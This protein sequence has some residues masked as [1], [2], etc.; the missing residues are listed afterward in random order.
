MEKYLNDLLN[1]I[2]IDNNSLKLKLYEMSSRNFEKSID[3][4]L[5][6]TRKFMQCGKCMD[7]TEAKEFI[8]IQLKIIDL[9]NLISKASKN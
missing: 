3:C 8:D 7:S 4:I 5:A 2:Y 6:C 1:D 9:L